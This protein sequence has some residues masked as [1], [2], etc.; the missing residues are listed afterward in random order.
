M[1]DEEVGD[2]LLRLQLAQQ[3]D[4]VRLHRDVEGRQDL[5]AEHQPR[6][7]RKR[8][9]DRDALPLAARELVRVAAGEGRVEPHVLERLA[10]AV[11]ARLAAQPEEQLQRTTHDLVHALAR[12]ER[13]IRVLEDELDLAPHVL[14][15]RLDASRRGPAL[16]A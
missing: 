8:A 10:H 6:P 9:G 13:G 14:A 5:V 11:S 15:A 12:V 1:R 16:E 7:C 2:P 3:L 4:D